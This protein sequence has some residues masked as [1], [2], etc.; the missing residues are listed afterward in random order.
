[1]AFIVVLKKSSVLRG[2]LKGGS[3][4]P[5]NAFPQTHTHTHRPSTVTLAAHAQLELTRFY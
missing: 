4:T 2:R 5:H 3:P 1:M